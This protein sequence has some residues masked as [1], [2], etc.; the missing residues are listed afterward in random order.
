MR[1]L[2][3]DDDEETRELVGAALEREGYEPDR[4]LIERLRGR[5]SDL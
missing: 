2:V 4:V 5:L 3:V 1:V